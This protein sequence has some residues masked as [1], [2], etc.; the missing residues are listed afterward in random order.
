MSERF[1]VKQRITD[2]GRSCV[3]YVVD[4]E[5]EFPSWEFSSQKTGAKNRI[6]AV[7]ASRILNKGWGYD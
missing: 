1:A 6:L 4:R 5:R 3:W 2:S 7:T